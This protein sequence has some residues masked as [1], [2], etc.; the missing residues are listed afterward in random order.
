MQN[1]TITVTQMKKIALTLAFFAAIFGIASAQT[2]GSLIVGI[3]GNEENSNHIEF[4]QTGSTYS[5][6]L[7]WL[8]KPNDDKGNP[9]VDKNNA[10]PKLRTRKLVGIPLIWGLSYLNNQ[11]VNGTVY[12]PVKGITAACSIVLLDAN[13]LKLKASKGIFSTTKIWKR[14]K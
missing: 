11:W 14:I 12:T 3:W 7:I 10:D 1:S 6:K 8:S 4:Y 9:K 13:T 5:A 2:S